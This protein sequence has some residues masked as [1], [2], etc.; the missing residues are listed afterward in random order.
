MDHI[1]NIFIIVLGNIHYAASITISNTLTNGG[2]YIQPPVIVV[3]Y[4]ELSSSDIGKG[5]IIQVRK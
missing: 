1:E 2:S 4:A 5:T 3:T